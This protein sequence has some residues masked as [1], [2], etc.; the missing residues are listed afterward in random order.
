MKLTSFY[1][2]VTTFVILINFVYIIFL[3]QAMVYYKIAVLCVLPVIG[4]N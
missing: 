3:Y 4:D 1:I 2:T